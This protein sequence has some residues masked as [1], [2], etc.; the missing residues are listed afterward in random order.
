MTASTDAP[1][2][3]IQPHLSHLLDDAADRRPEGVAVEDD[4]GPVRQL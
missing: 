3:Q 4:S 1:P 2:I